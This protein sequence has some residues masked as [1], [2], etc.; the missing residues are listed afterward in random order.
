MK[1]LD[2]GCGNRPKGD[3]N[4]DLHVEHMLQE[5]AGVKL[6]ISRS[7]AHT[8]FVIADA[9]FPSAERSF[10][11]TSR[12]GTYCFDDYASFWNGLSRALDRVPLVSLVAIPLFLALATVVGLV[13]A[14]RMAIA[15]E[16]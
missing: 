2:V 6:D 16:E 1:I 15:R 12:Y 10:A 5:E 13:E 11:G 4:I 14:I 3:V 7:Q 8:K 9:P